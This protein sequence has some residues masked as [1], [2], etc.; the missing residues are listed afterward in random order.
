[1]SFVN[2]KRASRLTT[3]VKSVFMPRI[4]VTSSTRNDLYV[5]I[6]DEDVELVSQYNWYLHTYGYVSATINCKKVLMHR[7]LMGNPSLD[8][9]HINGDRLDN[10]RENLRLATRSQNLANRKLNKNNTTGY[11]GVSFYRG[12]W[13]ATVGKELVGYF[14]TKEAAVKARTEAA[15]KKYGEFARFN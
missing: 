4:Q 9:D 2:N 7:L 3:R 14:K 8:V 15:C 1:M 6:D 12:R 13:R 11:R 5:I 10:R